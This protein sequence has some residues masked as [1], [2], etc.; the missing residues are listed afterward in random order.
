MGPDSVTPPTLE[1][2]DHQTDGIA[3]LQRVGRGL[4]ADSPRSGKTAQ[5]LIAAEGRTLVIAPPFLEGTWR[6]QCELWR[7]GFDYRFVGYNS[8]AQRVPND[9]GR[10]LRTEPYPKSELRGPWDTV[11]CDESHSLI[12]RHADW[13]Q[14]V[15]RIRTDHL[16]LA[17]GT[18]IANWAQDLL[19]TLRL[20]Y[21]GDKRFTNYKNW[22][23]RWFK[24]SLNPFSQ[25]LKPYIPKGDPNNGLL[26]KWTWAQFWMENGLDGPDGRMLNREVDLKVPFT[27]QD[28]NVNMTTAQAKFYKDLKKDYL[29]WLPSGEEVSLWDTGGLHT[30]LLQASTGLETLG[31][32]VGPRTEGS[33]KL[34]VVRELL[35]EARRQPTLLFC[36][37]RRTADA[38]EALAKQM[39]LRVGAIHG[40]VAYPIREKLRH[41]FRDGELDVLVGSVGTVSLGLNLARATQEIFVEHNP[42]PW[43]NDQAMKRAFEL[44]KIAHV[45]IVHLYTKDTVDIG[46][47]RI[48]QGKTNQQ[49]QAMDAREFREIID[50]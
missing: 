4:L 38:L 12:N 2:K 40:G 26:D 39:N 9:K 24:M 22:I 48:V 23:E 43:R 17:T 7:P 49:I 29:A 47:R 15:S 14:A 32:P 34:A 33:G 44:G 16:F 5:L 42:V 6:E 3:W 36:H 25:S 35:S 8:V 20:L 1:L 19:M 45:H 11:I 41:Q 21:P 10:L 37:F 46:L 13:T 50:G 18:P 31:E 27:E 30:K 28:I